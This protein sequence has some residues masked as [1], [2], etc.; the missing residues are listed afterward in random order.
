MTR[1]LTPV[2]VCLLVAAC[3]FKGDLVKPKQEIEPDKKEPL[4]KA[5]NS[6]K[7]LQK[8]SISAQNSLSQGLSQND[9]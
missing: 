9:D 7:S 2:V 4:K 5:S 1:L 6:R 8:L 3:G